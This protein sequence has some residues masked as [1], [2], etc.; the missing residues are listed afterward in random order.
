MKNIV[1][2]LKASYQFKKSVKECLK[3][4]TSAKEYQLAKKYDDQMKSLEDTENESKIIESLINQVEKD[5]T[6]GQST[7]KIQQL[8]EDTLS[9]LEILKSFTKQ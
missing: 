3:E 9:L 4:D 8:Q 2:L 7:Q 1:N 6:N 5:K